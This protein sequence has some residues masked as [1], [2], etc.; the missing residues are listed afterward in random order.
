MQFADFDAVPPQAGQGFGRILKFHRQM[1]SVVIDAEKLGQARCREMFGAEAVKEMQRFLGGFQKAK[2]FRLQAKMQPASG[3]PADAG[4][5][6]TQRKMFARILEAGLDC[7]D[8]FLERTGHGADASFNS[9]GTSC[10][11]RSNSRLV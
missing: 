3:L 6:S 9:G 2:R 11:S 8:E 10:P 1:A 5:C 7:R 4:I